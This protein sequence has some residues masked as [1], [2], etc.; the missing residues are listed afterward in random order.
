MSAERRDYAIL[1]SLSMREEAEVM[2][3]ALRA[4]GIDAFVGNV[5]HANVDWGWTIALGGMQVFVP[6]SSLAEAR[7]VIRAR[8][9]E[10]AKSPD[11]EAEPATRRDRWKAWTVLGSAFGLALF[12]A[13]GL[14]A[15][16]VDEY[17]NRVAFQKAVSSDFWRDMEIAYCEEELGRSGFEVDA[18]GTQEVSCEQFLRQ[19]RESR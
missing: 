1:I 5:H 12:G 2:A 13:G 7:D 15:H 3:S 11:P 14:T 19:F 10:V 8:L 16:T 4:E 9:S 18:R 6:A 17:H